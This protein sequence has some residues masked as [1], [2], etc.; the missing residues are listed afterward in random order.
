MNL[1]K[2]IFSIGF[3]TLFS[4]ILGFFRDVLIAQMFGAQIYT[5]AF[6][7]SFKIPNYL[8]KFFSEGI[9][10]Q[11]FLPILIG[12]KNNKKNNKFLK[13]FVS[14]VFCA[15]IIIVSLI[16]VVG[17]FFSKYIVLII[18]PG[19]DINTIKFSL[20]VHLLQIMFPYVLFSSLAIFI[21]S[22]LHSYNYFLIPALSPVIFNIILISCVYFVSSYFFIPIFSLAWGVILGSIFQFIYQ[23]P[24]LKKINMLVIPK[25]N[26][27]QIKLLKLIKILSPIVLGFFISQLSFLF[28]SFFSSY[29]ASGSISWIYYAN[30]IME[31]PV[32]I[33]GISLSTVLLPFLSKIFSL[34]NQ[35]DYN[36]LLD[37]GLRLSIVL[38]IPC[39]IIIG[40][41][42]YPII[43]SLF[44]YGYFNYFDSIMTSKALSAYS[45][46]LMA[47]IL[48][49][50]VSPA[51]YSRQNLKIP[52]NS[53]IISIILTQCMNFLLVVKYRHVGLIFSSVIGSW[54]HFVILIYY[55]FKKKFFIP[56]NKWKKFFY[57]I[58]ISSISMIFFL[59][60]F[61]KLINVWNEGSNIF[62]ITRLF[63]ILFISIFIYTMTL[64]FLGYNIKYNKKLY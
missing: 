25:I 13:K 28:N 26:I 23:I 51:F 15:T 6:F 33:I 38:G 24:F 14:S 34:G 9:F 29:I 40:I 2:S 39:S 10:F 12:Y 53:Y 61:L 57:R 50:I 41:F 36:N 35:K 4:K 46:G 47:F 19:F 42:S 30:R 59:I 7:L 3:I 16:S 32:G 37:W 58:L 1:L 11:A 8:K 48:I 18:A 27:F 21:S 44:Q 49:K 56:C 17:I 62:R 5:D 54:I 60:L 64:F 22:I 20:T 43:V 55:L 63:I 45:I 52:I 31:F